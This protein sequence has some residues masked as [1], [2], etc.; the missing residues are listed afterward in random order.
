MK[1][2]IILAIVFL[3]GICSPG[4]MAGSKDKKPRDVKKIML[5]VAKYQVKN[6]SR[7]RSANRDFPNGWVPASF[8]IGVMGAYEATGNK[9]YLKQAQTWA[10]SNDY[11]MGP[12]LRH[13]DDHACGSVYISLE[14]AEVKSADL[15]AVTEL[16]DSMIADPVPGREDWW[17][18]DALFM[19][20]PTLAQL[21]EITGKKQYHKFLHQM[22]WDT[23]EYLFDREDDLFYRDQRYFFRRSTHGE[24][25]F[26][27]RGN[28]WVIAG[29]PRIIPYLRDKDKQKQSYIELFKTLAAS[30]A[31]L[32]GEDGFWR[33]SLLDPQE[34]P[35]PE[36]SGSGFITYALA[37]G[38]NN[39]YLDRATY[40]P[41]VWK[42]WEALSNAVHRDGKIGWVQD[43]GMDPQD[44]SFENTHAYGAGAFLL[45]GSEI[46]NLLEKRSSP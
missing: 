44:V 34:Y 46:I 12:R 9:Y 28:G 23:A 17:W 2:R 27:S 33:S 8:Y 7:H 3:L 22:Y 10:E 32:Q 6:P 45:A 31:P 4:A 15:S 20:P 1:I 24:K 25:V 29:L 36:S 14:R 5:K 38:I 13:A 26:W 21:G 11:A 43:I 35:N 19:S 40:E 42:G 39:G 16:Y 41:L 18:C 37:W 30:L